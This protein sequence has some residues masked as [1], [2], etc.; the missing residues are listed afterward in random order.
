[1]PENKRFRKK[2]PRSQTAGEFFQKDQIFITA[3]VIYIHT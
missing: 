1:M 3:S 2:L